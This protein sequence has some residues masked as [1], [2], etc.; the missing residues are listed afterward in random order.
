VL[1]VATNKEYKGAM[2]LN[3][4]LI[5]IE[6]RKSGLEKGELAKRL[7]ISRQTLHQIY[8]SRRAT[9]DKIERIAKFF[10]KHP[11]DLLI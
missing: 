1:D 2:E 5:E 10:N 7:N 4:N 8:T 9:F 3:I 6:R 11:K